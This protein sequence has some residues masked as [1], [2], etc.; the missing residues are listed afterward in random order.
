MQ[1][2]EV[3]AQGMVRPDEAEK[4]GAGCKGTVQHVKKPNI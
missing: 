1:S 4:A 2:T 3:C